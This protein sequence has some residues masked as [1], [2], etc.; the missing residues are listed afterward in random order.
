MVPHMCKL[1]PY[2]PALDQPKNSRIASLRKRSDSVDDHDIILPK[3]NTPTCFVSL[4]VTKLG[5]ICSKNFQASKI[6]VSEQTVG[7]L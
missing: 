2:S 1:L 4:S 3:T 6:F 5:L 7:H